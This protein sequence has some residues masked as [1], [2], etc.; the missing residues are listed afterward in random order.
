MAAAYDF[1]IEKGASFSSA[2]VY[3]SDATTPVNLSGY[4][5]SLNLSVQKGMP[6]VLSATVSIDGPNGKINASFTASQTASIG[7]GEYY[8]SLV[9]NGGDSATYRLLEG[10]VSVT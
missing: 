3:K 5:G 9:I 10:T 2:F 7:L 1:T 6:S 4:T 8:Y